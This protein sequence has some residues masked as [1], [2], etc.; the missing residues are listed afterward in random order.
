MAFSEIDTKAINSIRVLAV[1]IISS[2]TLPHHARPKQQQFCCTCIF[3]AAMGEPT[4]ALL[5]MLYMWL[6]L[7]LLVFVCPT[8]Q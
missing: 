8:S 4:N 6:W 3:E 5:A 2:A 7:W 1:S